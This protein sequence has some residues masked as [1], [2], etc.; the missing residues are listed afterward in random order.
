MLLKFISKLI[1]DA[2]QHELGYDE[3]HTEKNSEDTEIDVTDVFQIRMHEK[4]GY[5]GK[6]P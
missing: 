1:E 3:H 5:Y 2:K 6:Y 4:A